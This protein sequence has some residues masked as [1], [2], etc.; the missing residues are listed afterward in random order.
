MQD[1]ASATTF[2]FTDIEGSTRLWEREPERMRPALAQHDA[3][4]RATI[5][6][7]GGALVKMTGDGAHAAFADPLDAIE[8]AVDLQQAL[9]EGE[10][11]LGI[12]LPVRCGLHL[13]I[14]ERRDN[15]FF[16]T[17]VNRAA[18][19]MAAAHGGQVLVS[20]AV[21]LR[22]AARMAGGLGLRDLGSVRLRDLTSPERVFQVLHPALRDRFPALRS[23]ESTPNNLPHQLTSFVGREQVLRDAQALLGRTRLLTLTGVGGLG[24][25]R[26]SLQLAAEVLDGFP[27]GVWFV[28]LAPLRAP[29]RVAQALASVLGVT[30]EPGQ[31]IAAALERFVRDRHLLL[32]LDNCEHLLDACAALAKSLL[33][34]GPAISV[35]ASS[36]EAFHIG[37]EAIF[38]LPALATPAR[39]QATSPVAVGRYEAVRLFAE[40]AVAARADF[41][42]TDANAAIVADLCSQLDGIPLALELAAARLRSM[43][44]RDI[45]MRLADRFALLRSRDQTLL[46][47][48]QTLRALIDW[49]YDLLADAEQALF[50]AL[51]VFAGGWTLAAAEAVGRGSASAE[52][53]DDVMD[54]LARLTEKSLVELDSG[55]R[56]RLLDTLRHYGHDRLREAGDGDAVHQRHLEHYLAL[57]EL[58]RPGLFG[59][60]Q[61]VWLARLDVERDNLLAAHACAGR[62]AHGA[63]AGLRLASAL[64][65]YWMNRG[66]LGLGYRM[67]VEALSRLGAGERGR[68]RCRALF[69]AGQLG[70]FMGKYAESRR[71]LEESLDIARNIGDTDRV[72]ALLQLLSVAAQ[73]EGELAT[74]RRYAEEAVELARAHPD[75][76]RLAAALNALAQQNRIEGALDAA[77][78]LY[79]QVHALAQELGDEESVA[80]ALLNHAMVHIGRGALAEAGRTLRE[81]IAIARR[82]G[83]QPVAQ[84]IF[85][86]SAALA[87]ACGD[88]ERAAGL[89]GAAETQTAQTGMCRDP[90]DEAFLGPHVAAIRQ[91]MASERDTRSFAHGRALPTDLAL[92]AAQAWLASGPERQAAVKRPAQNG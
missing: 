10:A 34:A 74:G 71:L 77:E 91:A 2:L 13:G 90:A 7:H 79:A 61:A 9:T 32:V 35:L 38:A 58:A 23:L 52:A 4:A 89:F 27:D 49:S 1:P 14:H 43:S 12:P 20:E 42:I 25:T 57:A 41:R 5:A 48:Q 59:P 6:R 31:P 65:F 62:S 37:G 24:K 15:D 85:E 70:V 83:S 3:I 92:D 19:I 16:G 40:R 63:E 66:L 67:A 81:V 50:R 72:A 80:I 21:A 29:E 53:G 36:R 22:V 45:G 51:S 64:S 82:T 11:V 68:L 86:V 33:A 87:S 17:A 8:A 78:A 55:G 60:E 46:P 84:S 44:V 39:G 30:E 28:E 47:R 76:R 54:V 75:R 69:D 18:R 73:G 26:L 88:W 56:Y